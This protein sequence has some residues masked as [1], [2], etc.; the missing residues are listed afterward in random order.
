MDKYI[1]GLVV[2]VMLVSCGHQ[3]EIDRELQ[4][5]G[6]YRSYIM[7]RSQYSLQINLGSQKYGDK[8]LLTDN[9]KATATDSCIAA[10]L[11]HAEFISLAISGVPVYSL[12]LVPSPLTV[13]WLVSE[14]KARIAAG[15]SL[16]SERENRMDVLMEVE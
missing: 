10:S 3:S 12:K 2:A 8:I 11:T 13:D 6:R 4:L 14:I 9:V 15:D 7:S 16:I 1:G 5:I